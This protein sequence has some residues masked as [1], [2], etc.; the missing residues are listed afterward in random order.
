[1][2]N[3][4]A[5]ESAIIIA[6]NRLEKKRL[7][8]LPKIKRPKDLTEA[9]QIQESLNNILIKQGLG[10]PVG[11]KIGCTTSVM[12]EYMNITEPSYGEIF[13]STVYNSPINLN[14]SDYIEPGV[15]AEIAVKLGLD[16]P[17]TNAPYNINSVVDAI[18][19][20]MTSI[21]VVDARYFDYRKLDT[22]TM[23]ADNF[24]NAACV[25]G[26]P[27]S[28]S[29]D[30]DLAN[31]QGNMKVNGNVIGK[32]LGS[33]IMGHPLQALA[34]LAN[35]L[36]ERNRNLKAGQFITLGSIVTTYWVSPGDLIEVE[37]SGL[38]SIKIKFQ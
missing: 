23:V 32:G 7:Q 33:L 29:K 28:F 34:W 36:A 10:M 37:M 11:F 19:N 27:H 3:Q 12:Q 9:Y 1:M 18:E 25:L 17:A 35:K 24:F 21:E 15:E 6:N 13:S 20:C 2:N 14:H 4:Q 8:Y 30:T 38:G 16:L 22:P 5:A 31:I 26:D